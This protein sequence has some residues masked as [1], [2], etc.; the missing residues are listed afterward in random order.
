MGSS[1]SKA[2][3]A[4][5][6]PHLPSPSSSSSRR[7]RSCRSRVFQS[8][9]LGSHHDSGN[10]AAQVT[11]SIYALLFLPCF[12]FY[13]FSCSLFL[14]NNSIVGVLDSSTVPGKL[15][16]VPEWLT[17]KMQV[18]VY[19]ILQN[20]LSDLGYYWAALPSIKFYLS[21]IYSVR[22]MKSEKHRGE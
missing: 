21:R 8:S 17:I 12:R 9:C 15:Y 14:V 22:R 11:H 4:D 19:C 1:S 2:N 13:L 16:I 7:T 20:A 5:S 18:F 3:A 10:A 6:S